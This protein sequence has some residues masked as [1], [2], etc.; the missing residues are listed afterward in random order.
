MDRGKPPVLWASHGDQR[1]ARQPA[2]GQFGPPRNEDRSVA[3]EHGNIVSDVTNGLDVTDESSAEQYSAEQLV[4]R[5]NYALASLNARPIE[6]DV[7]AI[8]CEAGAIGFRITVGPRLAEP[9]KERLQL[10]IGS[11]RIGICSG[12]KLAHISML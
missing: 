1:V 5:L 11:L 4:V 8:R 12:L 7:I 9:L 6:G 10:L 3:M 2:L